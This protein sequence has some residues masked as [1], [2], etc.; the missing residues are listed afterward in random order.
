MTSTN[1]STADTSTTDRA[2]GWRERAA[3]NDKPTD[4]F[5]PTPDR[6]GYERHDPA[7]LAQAKRICDTCLVREE[8]LEFALD[9]GD[10]YGVWGGTTKAER[11][12]LKRFIPRRKCPVCLGEDL[13]TDMARQVCCDCGHSWSIRRPSAQARANAAGEAA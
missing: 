13:R 4:L 1:T 5:F 10:V 3:C 2:D 12:R 7:A 8:C 6:Y 9:G 11:E